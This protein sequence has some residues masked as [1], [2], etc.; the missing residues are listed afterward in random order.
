MK[1]LF[2]TAVE[3]LHPLLGSNEA[4]SFFFLILLFYHPWQ[5]LDTILKREETGPRY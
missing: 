4:S 5:N 1:L 3:A 2:C